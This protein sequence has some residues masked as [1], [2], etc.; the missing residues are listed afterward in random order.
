MVNITIKQKQLKLLDSKGPEDILNEY[1]EF[2]LRRPL[3]LFDYRDLQNGILNSKTQDNIHHTIDYYF[4][5]YFKKYLCS[6]INIDKHFLENI[7]E[8]NFSNFYIGVSDE[9]TIT[10]IPIHKDYLPQFIETIEEKLSTYY[11]DIIGLHYEKGIKEIQIGEEIFYDFEKL[12]SIIK[13]HT[14]I[15]IHILDKSNSTNPNYE[16][17]NKFVYDVLEEEKEY[18]KE[19]KFYKQIKLKKKLYNEKYSQSFHLLIRN[20]IVMGEFKEYCKKYSFVIDD[21]LEL[22][23]E[24]IIYKGDVEKYLLNGNYISG[25][26]YPNDK[27]QDNYYGNKMKDYLKYYKEF[28][29]LKLKDNITIEPF[30]KK[31]PKLK[32]NSILK[33]I[34]CFTKHLYNNP[35]VYYIMIHIELP[36]IKDK[37]VYLGLK[38]NHNVKIIKRSFEHNLNMPCTQTN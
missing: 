21:I 25:S 14:K 7:L 13:R 22:L 19:K 5:K 33:N 3:T 35:N 27:I 38:D 34:S 10:G 36:F 24:K 4:D 15:N 29:I 12:L 30:Y 37:R 31:S 26:F 28:K 2:Y 1:K 20:D 8:E 11:K 17:I 16:K 32:L 23:K 9:G 6:L 18:D